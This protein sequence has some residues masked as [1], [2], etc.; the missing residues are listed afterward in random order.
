MLSAFLYYSFQNGVH[1]RSRITVLETVYTCT[2]LWKD[3]FV[4]LV[5]IVKVLKSTLHCKT[6]LQSSDWFVLCFT[7]V[8]SVSIN[9]HWI[10]IHI[11]FLIHFWFVIQTC[12]TVQDMPSLKSSACSSFAEAKTKKHAVHGWTIVRTIWTSWMRSWYLLDWNIK[13]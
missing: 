3:W 8:T 5:Y 1:A 9:L 13:R 7:M 12:Y 10:M 4:S 11:W 2:R 6:K